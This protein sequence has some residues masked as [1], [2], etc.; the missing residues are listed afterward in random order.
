ML[1]AI[2]HVPKTAGTLLRH[3]I[4]YA[5]PQNELCL[6][7]YHLR[8]D[9]FK[10]HKHDH[11]FVSMVR[12]PIQRKISQYHMRERN[13]H[14]IGILTTEDV[15]D[16]LFTNWGPMSNAYEFYYEGTSP[17]EMDFIGNADE[18]DMTKSLFY[19]MFG[20][21][22]NTSNKPN[23]NPYKESER[24]EVEVPTERFMEAFPKEYELYYEGVDKFYSLCKEY[25]VSK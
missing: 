3:S 24:Y 15:E 13:S 11:T 22:I 18:L 8:I 6:S 25:K 14:S 5:Y 20:I 17:K 12:D 10:K 4:Q 21:N 9:E 2:I 7:A 23:S 1:F 16:Y 19:N